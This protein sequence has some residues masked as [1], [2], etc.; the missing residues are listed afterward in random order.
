MAEFEASGSLGLA[1]WDEGVQYDCVSCM[2]AIHY[3]FES[4]PKAKQFL[5]NVAHNL[6]PGE[7]GILSL[8]H[9]ILA[10]ILLKHKRTPFRQKHDYLKPPRAQRR[11]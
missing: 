1:D 4:E 2:F 7:N 8:W 10:V 9:Q 3:F 5:K 6:K 11:A